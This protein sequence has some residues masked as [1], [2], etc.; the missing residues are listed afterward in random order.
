MLHVEKLR[1]KTL[2]LGVILSFA[3]SWNPENYSQFS[4]GSLPTL[5]LTTKPR[6]KTCARRVE[7]GA[8]RPAQMWFQ[9]M[10]TWHRQPFAQSAIA[11]RPHYFSSAPPFRFSFGSTE[12]DQAESPFC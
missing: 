8:Q 3:L 2:T 12:L 11:P 1:K 4:S 9:P 10:V 6:A 7:L 5:V